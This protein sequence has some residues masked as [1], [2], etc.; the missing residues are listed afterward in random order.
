MVKLQEKLDMLLEKYAVEKE[1]KLIDNGHVSING[2]IVPLL[3]WRSERRFFEMKSC[4]TNGTLGKP[5]VIRVANTTNKG[6][7]MKCLLAREADIC[8]YTLGSEIVSVMVFENGDALNAVLK[9]AN[10]VIC[11]IELAA[12]LRE[13]ERPVDKHEI[14]TTRG[15]TCDKVVDT[16][17]MQSSIYVL[18]E[19]H[20]EYTDVD[21]ELYGLSI[22][23]TAIVR[24]A[25]EAAKKDDWS[26]AIAAEAS[27]RHFMECAERSSKNCERVDV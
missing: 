14:A 10:D 20:E 24:A 5:S 16:Q 2:N 6:A 18:G 23:E 15:T 21:F 12:T 17:Y 4:V 25:F 26:E 8:R 13:G 19:A 22:D 3:P 7:C 1:V 11:T 27:L 9:L